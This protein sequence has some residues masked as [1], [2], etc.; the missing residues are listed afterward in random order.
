MRWTSLLALGLV[1]VGTVLAT[2]GPRVFMLA[3]SM[4]WSAAP[5]LVI[6][7]G[8]LALL[9]IAVPPPKLVLPGILLSSGAVWLAVRHEWIQIDVGIRY[10]VAALAIVAGVALVSEKG[11][12]TIDLMRRRWAVLLSRR[13]RAEVVPTI[14]RLVAMRAQFRLEFDNAP[15]GN[16]VECMIT[17]WWGDVELVVPRPYQ[18]VCGRTHTARWVEFAGQLDSDEVFMD[19]RGMHLDVLRAL[20]TADRPYVLVLHTLGIGG[21]VRVSRPAT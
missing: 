17:T 1:V 2:S 10:A 15:L 20:C 7:L 16:V 21:G 4:L 3:A 12:Q 8:G 18:V 19:P 13:A 5:V 6:A 11:V 9:M 14:I